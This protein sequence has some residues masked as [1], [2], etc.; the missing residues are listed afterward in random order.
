M[1]L[2][3][4][5]ICRDA[6][7]VF[8]LSLACGAPEV[9]PHEPVP[10]PEEQCEIDEPTF[11]TG[12]PADWTSGGQAWPGLQ[13]WPA[14]GRLYVTWSSPEGPVFTY[15]HLCGGAV[16]RLNPP[17]LGIDR[18]AST[19]DRDDLMVYGIDW[20]ED[21]LYLLDRADT[22][23]VDPPKLVASI[24]H[25]AD[26]HGFSRGLVL[27]SDGESGTTAEA[28]GVGARRA[29]VQVYDAA[30]EEVVQVDDQVIKLDLLRDE[31]EAHAIVL[32]RDDG[33]LSRYDLATGVGETLAE[34]VRTYQ[35]S[36]GQR[37]LV[38]Q[39]IADGGVESAHLR[40]VESGAEVY[41]TDNEFAAWEVDLV[42][43]QMVGDW[44]WT[45]DERFVGL[46]TPE[47]ALVRVYDT[48]TAEPVEVPEHTVARRGIA[49]DYYVRLG[50][51]D[52]P[53]EALWT[54]ATGD[55]L[56]W[57]EGKPD[58]FLMLRR[59][60]DVVEY[61]I[62]N[63]FTEEMQLWA[64]DRATGATT[65]KVARLGDAFRVLSDGR[66]MTW[67]ARF[68]G[69]YGEPHQIAVIDPDTDT[70]TIVVDNV[71]NSAMAGEQTIY[72]V[73]A[74][75]PEDGVWAVPFPAKAG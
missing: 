43:S 28:A 30:R 1:D 55:V 10:D 63:M 16:A 39:E 37:Y 11:I 20:D 49:G 65:L 2:M 48:A 50:T 32:L 25:E 68:Y 74:D 7:L 26:V 47:G 41:L 5:R 75:A 42:S 9:L 71:V 35:L 36:P 13:V 38:W 60:D 4:C 58:G 8:A 3:R 70:T 62:Q 54:P 34:G 53:S 69:P 72:Y 12:R 51:M 73:D 18:L 23:G 57:F 19:S 45:G 27:V 44:L 33:R 66:L 21:V 52:A 15:T 40:E 29:V 67:F 24:P 17:E 61:T 46:R 6:G 14:V 31:T 22:P 59:A 64:V 56:V